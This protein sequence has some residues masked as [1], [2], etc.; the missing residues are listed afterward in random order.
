MLNKLIEYFKNFLLEN[1]EFHGN[2]TVNFKNGGIT[3]ITEVK[4]VKI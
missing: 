3:N 1:P 2:I 4:S